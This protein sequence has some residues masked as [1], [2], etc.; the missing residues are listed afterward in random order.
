[1]R[2]VLSPRA[3][4]YRACFSPPAGE[5]APRNL[6]HPLRDA[7]NLVEPISVPGIFSQG[8]TSPNTTILYIEN[9]PDDVFLVRRAMKKAGIE[10][11]VA[12]VENGEQ[13]IA[14]LQAVG[15]Y[16]DPNQYP[17]PSLVLVDLN[18]PLLNGLEFLDWRQT[19]ATARMIPVVVFTSSRHPRDV[20]QAYGYGA[21]GYLIKP[22]APDLLLQALQALNSFW[23]ARAELPEVSRGVS[24]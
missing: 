7:A 9:E 24:V 23:L 3:Q 6:L 2:N 11:Q 1:M 5:A 15:R 13:A 18:M 14:Y 8:V 19:D 16:S 12:V 22:S 4:R 17:L 10:A 21:N 20:N